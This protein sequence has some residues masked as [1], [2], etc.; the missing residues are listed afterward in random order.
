MI[1]LA[2]AVAG[3]LLVLAGLAVL[4]LV[5]VFFPLSWAARFVVDRPEH[6]PEWLPANDPQRKSA[7]Q[8]TQRWS[9]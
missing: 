2:W 5:S 4:L 9:A 7:E 6:V 1:A 8:A 3:G